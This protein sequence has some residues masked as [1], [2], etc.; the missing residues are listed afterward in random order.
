MDGDSNLHA[1]AR[2]RLDRTRN[3]DDGDRM[4]HVFQLSSLPSRCLSG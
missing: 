4:H 1:A 2:V 3:H